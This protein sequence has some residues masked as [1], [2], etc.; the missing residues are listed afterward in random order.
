MAAITRFKLA[1]NL[2]NDG[3]VPSID[4]AILLFEL[5]LKDWLILCKILSG[6]I[7]MNT[8]FKL[9]PKFTSNLPI[10]LD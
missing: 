9:D 6:I 1:L 4:F 3:L 8:L 2:S 10:K 5:N 7:L